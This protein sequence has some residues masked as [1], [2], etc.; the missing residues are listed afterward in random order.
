MFNFYSGSVLKL[1]L[2]RCIHCSRC[3]RFFHETEG[4]SMLSLVFR[5]NQSK[6]V[7]QSK[8]KVSSFVIGNVVDLCPVGYL[9]SKKCGY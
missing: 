8:K 7:S 2:N 1:F 5:G 4:S 3:V 9:K 6:I